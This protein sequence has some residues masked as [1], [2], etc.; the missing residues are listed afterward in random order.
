MTIS[1]SGDFLTLL[2]RW[3][4]SVWKAVWK[5]ALVWLFLYYSIRLIC[6]VALDDQQM[7]HM[8][9]LSRLFDSFTAKI[10]LQFLLGFYVGQVVTRWW[11]QVQAVP[12]PDDCMVWTNAFFFKDDA[13]TRV[14]RRLIARYL[15]LCETLVLRNVSTRIRLRFPTIQSLLQ[16]GLMTQEEYALYQKVTVENNRWQLPLQWI[17]NGII[18]PAVDDN[19]IPGAGAATLISKVNDF[20]N[21]L[22]LIYM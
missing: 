8:K 1:Y 3:K 22:R 20:R 21:A 4:G 7:E 9:K 11:A 10:P 15:I 17:I 12:W 2:G 5:E 18:V 16:A 6:I 14:K 19:E 13:A